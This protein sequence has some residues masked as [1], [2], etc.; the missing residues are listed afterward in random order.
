MDEMINEEEGIQSIEDIKKNF[1]VKEENHELF[2]DSES[3]DD[4]TEDD[5]ISPTENAFMQGYNQAWQ[6]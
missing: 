4:L 3:L 1:E 2:Y 5:E 6:N